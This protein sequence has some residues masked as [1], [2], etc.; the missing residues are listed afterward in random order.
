MGLAVVYGIVQSHGGSIV[1]ESKIGKGTSFHIFL[2]FRP[3]LISSQ[4]HELQ[5]RGKTPVPG[6]GTILLVDDH[7]IVR[8]VG[9]TMLSRLGYYVVT[10]NDGEDALKYYKKNH[11]KIDLVLIDLVMPKLNGPSC[12]KELRKIDPNV[13][14]ILTTG[15]GMNS[16]VQSALDSGML[17][18]IRKPYRLDQLSELVSRT[19]AV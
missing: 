19:I 9:S 18:Y 6:K 14:S 13:R 16:S 3:D 2:P 4:T 5:P 8:S 15:Y 7:E 11:S 17:G 10:A 1:V 12:Y